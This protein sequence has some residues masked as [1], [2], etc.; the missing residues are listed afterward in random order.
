MFRRDP[1][2]LVDQISAALD[3]RDERKFA[4]A[5]EKLPKAVLKA[6]PEQVQDALVKLVPVLQTIG[7]GIGGDVARLA[8]SMGDYGTDAT[9]VAPVLALRATVVLEQAVSFEQAYR[10]AHGDVPSASFGA[11]IPQVLERFTGDP[12]LVEAWFTAE[13]WAQPVL[14][15]SQRKDVRAVLAGLPDRDRLVAAVEAAEEHVGPAAWLHGLLRVLDDEP[16]IVLHRATGRA[17]RVTISGIGDNFQLHT[18]LAG[19]LIGGT[20]GLPGE[21]PS[22]VELAAATDGEPQPDGGIRG[23][24]NLVDHAGE[25]IWN[26]GRP[27]DIPALDGVRVIVIDPAPYARSW[28]AGRVYPLMKPELT[29][30]GELP[31]AEAAAWAARVKP[32]NR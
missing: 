22:A 15:L 6:R 5:L 17:F 32:S 13:D 18:L 4:D 20:A 30:H 25:W 9:V 29:V 10:S 14:F 23:N 16:L 26:E 7:T 27:A 31:A 8:G 21:P 12:A 24:F 19:A 1:G 11:V 2:R 3:Q 28:N